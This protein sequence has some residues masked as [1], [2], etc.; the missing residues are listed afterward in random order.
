MS[1]ECQE[2]IHKILYTSFVKQSMCDPIKKTQNIILHKKI[3]SKL[4]SPRTIKKK[5]EKLILK[6]MSVWCRMLVK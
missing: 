1:N 5:I 4:K 6:K 3:H 2:K